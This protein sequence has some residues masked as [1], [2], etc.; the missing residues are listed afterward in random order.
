M[1]IQNIEMES[2]MFTEIIA[3]CRRC[4]SVVCARLYGCLGEETALEGWIF[5]CRA[6]SLYVTSSNTHHIYS[7][8]SA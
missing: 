1:E 7:L 8:P 2:N 4:T 6:Q 3:Q 5:H